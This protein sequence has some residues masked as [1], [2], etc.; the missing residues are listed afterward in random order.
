MISWFFIAPLPT[1]AHKGSAAAR[2]VGRLHETMEWAQLIVVIIHVATAL[3]HLFFYRD[4]ILQRMPP[5][6]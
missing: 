3:V 5:G 2:A 1:L 6:S 4:R